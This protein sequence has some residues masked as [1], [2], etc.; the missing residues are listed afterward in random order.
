MPQDPSPLVQRYHS[1]I[2]EKER[3]YKQKG[4]D[5]GQ[6]LRNEVGLR[7]ITSISVMRE[8]PNITFVAHEHRGEISAFALWGDIREKWES[9]GGVEPDNDAGLPIT[10]ELPTP[11]EIGRFNHFT[12]GSIYWKPEHGAHYVKGSIRNLWARM[13]WEKSFLGYPVTD[14]IATPD[15]KGYGRFSH[16]EGGSIYWT[17]GLG[18]QVVPSDI[19]D[20]WATVSH[21]RGQ[22]GFPVGPGSPLADFPFEPGTAADD[23]FY[24]EGG[25][26][27]RQRSGA[28]R[29]VVFARQ[30]EAFFEAKVPKDHQGLDIEILFQGIRCIKENPGGWLGLGDGFSDSD[31]PYF[32]VTS[33]DGPGASTK[34][35]FGKYHDVDSGEWRTDGGSEAQ[36]TLFVSR[37]GTDIRPT[38]V[39]IIA[40]E[41]DGGGSN[42]VSTAV[43]AAAGAAAA[44]GG[45][46]LAGVATA[47]PIVGGLAGKAAGAAA[48]AVASKIVGADDDFIATQTYTFTRGNMLKRALTLPDFH[49][50]L[51]GSP[52]NVGIPLD[53]GGSG[54]YHAYLWVRAVAV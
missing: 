34:R 37:S 1:A 7:S 16:F 52:V 30:S 43:G 17:P 50:R 47:N 18:A 45:A 29:T 33:Y 54:H 42:W 3:E 20:R 38:N 4:W 5:L 9:M 22:M 53:G 12:N 35:K 15:P 31:E 48:A 24:F 13:G 51:S 39:T 26:I 44:K 49:P 27:V 46:V 10:D 32:V 41:D 36:R 19:F 11:D 6:V 28:P 21:E 2:E 8:Y 23:I 14:E 25:Y 40:M